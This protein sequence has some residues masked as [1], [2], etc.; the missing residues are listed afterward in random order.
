[1]KAVVAKGKSRPLPPWLQKGKGKE[2]AEEDKM[3]PKGGKAVV[4]KKKFADGGK[5]NKGNAINQKGDAR[6]DPKMSGNAKGNTLH[7]KDGGKAKCK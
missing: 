2:G 3:P 5:V 1:M 4:V 7:L 6:S